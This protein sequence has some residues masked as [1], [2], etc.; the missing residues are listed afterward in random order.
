M[1]YTLPAVLIGGPPHAGKSVLLYNL[2]HALYERGVRHHAIRACPDGEGNWFQEGDPE[3][4]S[5]IRDSN[6][7]KWTGEFIARMSSDLEHRCLPF[8][9]DMGGEPR[10]NELALFRQ[11][12]HAILLLRADK[13]DAT[14]L[15]HTMVTEADLLPLADLYS[16]REGLATITEQMPILKGTMTGLERQSRTV[17]ES[18]VF[19]QLVDRIAAL[20]DSYAAQDMHR[21]FLRQAQ[22]ELVLDLPDALRS[23][24]TTSTQWQPEHLAPFLASIPKDVQLSVHGRGPNWLYAALI[25]HAG[26]RPF[27]LFDPKLSGWIQ[28]LRVRL[29]AET[30]NEVT[31]TKHE[32]PDAT[33]LSFSFPFGRLEY[34]QPDPLAFP[35]VALERGLIFDGPL[36]YWLLTALVRLYQ[37]AGVAWIAPHHAQQNGEPHQKTAIVSYSRVKTRR[38]GDFITIAV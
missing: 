38:I 21:I 6:K 5:I 9:V 35:S 31:V 12:T 13:P 34:F 14:R 20:F 37:D 7:S 25:A 1:V 11:C 33:I 23:Y 18:P 24:T 17:R 15:W 27:Y 8:L 30:S 3:I 26:Q 29:D 36:P 4:V 22:T 28:P 19:L 32:T 10:T 16:S 2:T